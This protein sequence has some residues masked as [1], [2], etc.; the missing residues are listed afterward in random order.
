MPPQ[1]SVRAVST[2]QYLASVV[3]SVCQYPSV[4]VSIR[5]Y[6]SVLVRQYPSVLVSIRQYLSKLGL[7][8]Q[9]QGPRSEICNPPLGPLAPTS[10]LEHCRLFDCEKCVLRGLALISSDALRSQQAVE[11]PPPTFLGINKLWGVSL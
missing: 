2:C 5:Q 8:Q 6:P 9:F 11:G 3:V 1:V 7:M 4:L 10:L